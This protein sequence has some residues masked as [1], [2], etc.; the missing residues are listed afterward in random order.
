MGIRSAGSGVYTSGR[1]NNSAP[2]TSPHRGEPTRGVCVRGTHRLRHSHTSHTD[3]R[4]I[5]DSFI[6]VIVTF[7]HLTQRGTCRG[8]HLFWIHTQSPPNCPH[9]LILDSVI[10]P[11]GY[12][13]EH[14]FWIHT[15]SPPTD[16]GLSDKHFTHQGGTHMGGGLK[17]RHAHGELEAHGGCGERYGSRVRE[18]D[19][20]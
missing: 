17:G 15:Q 5:H 16:F 3:T 10:D 7:T 18:N 13:G 1:E 20:R 4:Y 2:P 14:L 19:G 6:I 9:H 12:R 8:E 11:K